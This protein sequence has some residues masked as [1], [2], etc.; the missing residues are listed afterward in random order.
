MFGDVL[1]GET[2]RL[3][4]VALDEAEEWLAGEDEEQVRWFEAPR[5]AT[6]S[7]V[8]RAISEW[9]A[10]WE[11][12]GG[13]RHWGV[14]PRNGDTILGG[15]ELRSLGDA[16]VNL[17]YLVFPPYRRRGIAVQACRLVVDYAAREM[18]AERVI[19]KMLAGNA[20]SIA[21][22]RQ[23]GATFVGTGPSDAGG[24]FLINAIDVR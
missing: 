5:P 9:Q 24:T 2:I 7:D 18:G 4:P 21:V 15:V 3:Q 8:V 20:A 19:V 12:R 1:I 17:S 13:V 14:R 11:G 23:L 10:S 22:A 6:L 16:E